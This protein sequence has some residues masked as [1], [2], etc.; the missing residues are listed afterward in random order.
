M[1]F[2]PE[3]HVNLEVSLSQIENE[4]FRTVEMPLGYSNLFKEEWD[5]VRT[6]ADDQLKKLIRVHV[7][8]HETEMT[9]LQRQ[10]ISFRIN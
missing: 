7:L 9:I 1:F 10:K 5:I 6:L 2:S 3:G 4:L 8:L